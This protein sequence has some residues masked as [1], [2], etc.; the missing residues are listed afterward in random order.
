MHFERKILHDMSYVM[1]ESHLFDED[2]DL[3][4]KNRPATSVTN[5]AVDN[6]NY[7]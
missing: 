5:L 2:T 3:E 6:T 7:K 4:K 1:R